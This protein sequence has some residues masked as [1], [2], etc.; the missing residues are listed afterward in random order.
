[1]TIIHLEDDH[2]YAEYIRIELMEQAKSSGLPLEI[3]RIPSEWKF[4]ES[5]DEII[6]KGDA[7]LL[8]VMVRW[9]YPEE[10]SVAGDPPGEYY[11]AGLRCVKK[12]INNLPTNAHRN[13]VLYTVYQQEEIKSE[14]EDINHLSNFHKVNIFTKCEDTAHLWEMLSKKP[15]NQQIAANS[16]VDGA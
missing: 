8:D 16:S 14:L 5:I 6:T 4:N 15:N 2:L 10:D 3:V 11:D 1:M 9:C 13:I 12:L 7:F